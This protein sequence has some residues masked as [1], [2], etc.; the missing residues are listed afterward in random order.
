MYFYP[1]LPLRTK[2]TFFRQTIFVKIFVR[3]VLANFSP[4]TPDNF[5][6]TIFLQTVLKYDILILD[7]FPDGNFFLQM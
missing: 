3:N 1:N 2:R 5:P 4:K 6:M 7:R